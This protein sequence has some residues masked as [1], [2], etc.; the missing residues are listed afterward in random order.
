MQPGQQMGLS[1][2]TGC[3]TAPHLHF[4]AYRFVASRNTFAV[5]DP[6]GWTSA[7]PGPVGQQPEW[8]P[9]LVPVAA[10]PGPTLLPGS[11]DPLN[12]NPGNNA[13]VGI[14]RVRWVGV[15]DLIAPNNEF[16]DVTIDSRYVSGGT[17]DL[18]GWH[19][20]N[21]AGTTYTFPTG[22][23]LTTSTPTIHVFTGGGRTRRPSCTGAGRAACGTT[24][25]TARI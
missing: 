15:N 14:T 6:F 16:V 25:A 24:W 2:N 22:T 17:F 11:A 8:G 23:K 5:I 4:G 1:G 21:N 13:P 12:P 3:S 18:G 10:R 19:L 7:S 20:R 9:E